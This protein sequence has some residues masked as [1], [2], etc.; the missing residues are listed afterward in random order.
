MWHFQFWN[1][2]DFFF[3]LLALFCATAQKSLSSR[4]SRLFFQN[5][6]FSSFLWIVFSCS[7]TWDSTGVKFQNST[8]PTVSVRFQPNFMIKMLVMGE[9]RLLV[10]LRCTNKRPM[11][12]DALLENHLAICQSSR[13]CTYTPFLP[14]GS[15]LSLFSLWAWAAVYD[16]QADFQNSHISAWNVV[17][18]QSARSCTY[19]LFPHQ[20]VK[21]E[22]IFA[23]R[24]VVSEI[25]ADFQTC[26][27]WAWILANVW[28]VI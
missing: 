4:S 24:A 20:G 10:F 1:F 6:N 8:S 17:I 27:I 16:I 19:T 7:L 14:Q 18:G 2:A 21:I 15:K 5:V 22:L 25:R 9:H 3:S 12:L 11:G 23:L 26:H 13:S 28:M